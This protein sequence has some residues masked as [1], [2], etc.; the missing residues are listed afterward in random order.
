FNLFDGL[1]GL[2]GGSVGELSGLDILI[3]R[4]LDDVGNAGLARADLRDEQIRGA[5]LRILAIGDIVADD[6]RYG[7][8]LF[9]APLDLLPNGGERL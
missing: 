5:L 2:A 1:A 6:E 3:F 7:N 8:A 9:Q 4:R